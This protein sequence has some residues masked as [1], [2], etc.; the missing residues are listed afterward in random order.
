MEDDAVTI[1]GPRLRA[2][3]YLVLITA[4]AVLGPLMAAGVVQSLY[5]TIVQS[6]LGVF[7]GT[8]A[9]ANIRQRPVYQSRHAAIEDG[10][11]DDDERYG[12]GAQ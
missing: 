6:L 1:L 11:E 4:S 5:G 9:L 2:A 12:R 10:D 3:I 7:G 8:T